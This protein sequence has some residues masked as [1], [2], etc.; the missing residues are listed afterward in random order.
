M[1]KYGYLEVFQ[2]TFEFE[3]TRV[4]CI[5]HVLLS[6]NAKITTFRFMPQTTIDFSCKLYT[7]LQLFYSPQLF[8]FKF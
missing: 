1:S 5:C 7:V 2:I 3:I 6:H 4:D 8:C